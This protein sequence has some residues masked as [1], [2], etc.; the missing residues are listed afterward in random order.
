MVLF[1]PEPFE[2]SYEGHSLFYEIKENAHFP[3]DNK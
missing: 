1:F 2:D 3:N